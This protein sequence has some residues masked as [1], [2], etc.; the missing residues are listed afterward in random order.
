MFLTEAKANTHLTHLEELILTQGEKGY[1]QAKSFL[2]ELIKN[3]KG[4]TDAKASTSVKWD[5][6][7]AIFAGI[8]PENGKFFV[9]TKSVFNKNPKLNYTKEDVEKNHGHAPGLVD[10]LKRALDHLP[11][12]G[13]DKILQGDF[14]FDDGMLQV[15]EMDGEPHYIFKP[16]TITYAVPVESELGEKIGNAKFGIVFHTTYEDLT[17]GASYG[18]DVSN[19]KKS[20]DIWFSDAFFTDDTGYVTLT[21]DEEE[22]II[23]LIKKA[24][25]ININYDN[26]PSALLNTYI[27]SEIRTGQFLEDPRK[28]FDNFKQW[29]QAK[30]DKKISTLKTE[31]GQQRAKD[32]G[33]KQMDL[34]ESKSKDIIK[35][36]EVSKLLSEAKSIFVTKYNNAVYNTKH[37][38]DDGAGGL[39]VTNPEGYVAVDH[40]GNGVKLVDRLEFSRA[41]FAMDKGFTKGNEPSTEELTESFTVVLSADCKIT[42]PINEWL[43]ELENPRG[44]YVALE[45]RKVAA[46]SKEIYKLISSG[47]PVVSFLEKS[48]HVK[49]AIAGAIYYHLNESAR[50]RPRQVDDH[51]VQDVMNLLLKELSINDDAYTGDFPEPPEPEEK[52][53]IL[54][55][56]RFQPMGKHHLEVFK[57]LEQEWGKGNVYIITSDKVQLPKSPLNF[58]EKKQIMMKHGIPESQIL[59][60]ASPYSGRAL[61]EYFDPSKVTAVYAVGKKDMDEDPRFGNL[62]GF[63]VDG[64]TPAWYKSYDKNKEELQT[65]DKHGYVMVAPHVSM[66]IEGFGEMCGTTIRACLQN[67]TPEAFE[68]L[69]GWFDEDIYNMVKERISGG[70][71]KPEDLTE[72]LFRLI[73]EVLDEDFDSRTQM[74]YLY[75]QKPKVA[76][77]LASKMTKK[78]YKNLPDKV[79]ESEEEL[80]EIHASSDELFKRRGDDEEEPETTPGRIKAATD[81]RMRSNLYKAIKDEEERRRIIMIFNK[82]TLEEEELDETSTMSGGAVGGS[83]DDDSHP[84][85]RGKIPGIKIT[86][87]SKQGN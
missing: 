45:E 47:K 48:E 6:A 72:S 15:V 66:D 21:D 14:M 1:R 4:H 75:S 49:P 12:L 78:D 73:E 65:Y 23:D 70:S 51:L 53:I 24:D 19:L 81:A 42:K 74:K 5:G 64:V 80:D 31:K 87:K 10:K 61:D 28:S 40:I 83:S 27:N 76:K 82:K 35:I 25:A 63:R 86:Y 68:G 38:V 18:A 20:P 34:V 59:F 85:L 8:N 2:F 37:F 26:L 7:P 43:L 32:A 11:E 44:A 54:Y 52:T 9:G 79:K 67:L 58:E 46:S 57:K 39:K 84:Q 77:Q 29:Y 36:F 16:N 41:N 22:K 60:A 55:P 3:L 13:I 62:D 71:Q 17:S 69:M 33:D 30:I 56:G 50:K